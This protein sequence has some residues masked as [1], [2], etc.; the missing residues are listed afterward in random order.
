[1]QSIFILKS[2][3]NFTID[4][5]YEIDQLKAIALSTKNSNLIA[6]HFKNKTNVII[7]SFRRV[8]VN[9]FLFSVAHL[10]QLKGFQVAFSEN[11]NI[12]C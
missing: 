10:R 2:D 1:M 3:E 6:F 7:E 8:E 5:K 12:I 4:K 9:L 11:I